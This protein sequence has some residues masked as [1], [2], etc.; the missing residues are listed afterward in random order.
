M[1]EFWQWSQWRWTRET[2]KNASETAAGECLK[3]AVMLIFVTSFLFT[4]VIKQ[5]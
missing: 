3:Y 1:G 2:K 4:V 5:S